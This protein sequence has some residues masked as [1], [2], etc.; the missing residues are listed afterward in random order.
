MLL[1]ENINYGSRIEGVAFTFGEEGD[2]LH[3]HV[4]TPEVNDTHIVIVAR[5]KLR[6]ETKGREDDQ[7]AFAKIISEGDLIDVPFGI[8]HRF[9]GLTPGAKIFNLCKEH[10][11]CAS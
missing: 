4:H 8:W 5:G 3:W 9:V 6:M 10:V 11:T 7:V 2:A 1:P